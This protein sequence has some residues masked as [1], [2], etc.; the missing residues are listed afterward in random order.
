MFVSVDLIVAFAGGNMPC[1]ADTSILTF[2]RVMVKLDIRIAQNIT[3]SHGDYASIYKVLC[4]I[5]MIRSGYN[6]R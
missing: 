4:N 2:I 5:Q 6:A 1:M 3:W